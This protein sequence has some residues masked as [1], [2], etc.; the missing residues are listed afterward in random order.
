MLE[1]LWLGRRTGVRVHFHL[2]LL[3]FGP[4]WY[5]RPCVPGGLVAFLSPIRTC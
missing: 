5:V 2:I 3:D 4:G 1:T